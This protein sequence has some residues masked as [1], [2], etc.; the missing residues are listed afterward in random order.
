LDSSDVVEGL[1]IKDGPEVEVL[2][3]VSLHGGLVVS[4]P[5][6]TPVTAVF[7]VASLTTHGREVGWPKYAQFDNA[8]ISQGTHRYP[9]ALGPVLRLC[10]SR[11]VVPVFV[12]P[13]EMGFQAMIASSNG[14][15]QARVRARFRHSNLEHLRDRSS[16]H[17]AA[18]RHHRAARIEAAPARRPFPKNWKLKLKIRPRGT[19]VYVRRTNATGVVNR[20][21]SEWTVSAAWPN[22]LVRREVDLDCDKSA[23]FTLRR[24][25]PASQPRTL[26]VEYRLPHRGFQD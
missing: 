13:R 19:V 20:L 11:D 8:M 9:D 4:W 18:L 3:G 5:T 14:W 12:P 10:L 22:R 16:R 26:E 1:V 23:F 25:D 24:R 17:V 21:G 7:T 6:A 2:N 15:W